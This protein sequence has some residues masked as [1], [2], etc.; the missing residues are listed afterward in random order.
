M[1]THKLTEPELLLEEELELEDELE[2]LLLEEELELEDEP[3]QVFG[4]PTLN[5]GPHRLEAVG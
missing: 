5:Q 4:A 2:E 1:P 3:P